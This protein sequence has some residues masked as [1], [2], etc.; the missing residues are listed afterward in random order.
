MQF[1]SASEILVSPT[2]EGHG[3]LTGAHGEPVEEAHVVIYWQQ[4]GER[5]ALVQGHTGEH[6]AYH[7]AFTL[8]PHARKQILLLIE[9]HW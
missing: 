5:K 8:P 6:G 7:L 9:T 2:F 4:L 3:V 1:P